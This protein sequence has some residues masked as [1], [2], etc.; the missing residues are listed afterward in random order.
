MCCVVWF[1]EAN[2][3]LLTGEANTASLSH[4]PSPVVLI[5]RVKSRLNHPL[6]KEFN[7][8]RGRHQT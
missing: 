6:G 8:Q 5:L 3:P 7:D 2:S 4:T 1:R